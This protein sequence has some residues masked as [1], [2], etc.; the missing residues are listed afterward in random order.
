MFCMKKIPLFLK[1][2][3]EI[4]SYFIAGV[5]TTIVSIISYNLFRLFQIHYLVSTILSWIFAVVFAYVINKFYVFQSNN[6][7][8]WEFFHFIKYRLFS[9]TVE[10][11][12][13]YILV[14]FFEINDSISKIIVQGF[15]LILNYLFSKIFV[16]KK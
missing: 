15:V 7:S 11:I 9:L 12:I 16:F 2:Y 4:I 3:E 10:F 14:D 6:K 5:F 13:M 8:I 1:Q